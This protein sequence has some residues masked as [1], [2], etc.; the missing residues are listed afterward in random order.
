MGVASG[1]LAGLGAGPIAGHA[2]PAM[3]AGRVISASLIGN[4]MEWYD[5]G[6]YGY[7]A[8]AM[9]ASFFP[10]A[11]RTSS[12]LAAF[13]VF[14]VGFLARPLGGVL[15]GHVGDRVGRKRALTAS[16]A[17][18]AVPTVLI[19][20]LPTHAQIGALAGG[21]AGVPAAPAGAGRRG[22]VHQLDRLCRRACGRPASR[23]GR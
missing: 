8:V 19:G 15:F 12:T 16:V 21:G 5:F 7:F 23:S 10:A 17:L 13:A 9:G 1:D 4:V 3:P 20:L 2:P 6:I 11:D 22:R 14:A 18:M